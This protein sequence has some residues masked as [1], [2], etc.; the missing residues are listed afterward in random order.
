MNVDCFPYANHWNL[1][2][3]DLQYLGSRPSSTLALGRYQEVS[4][5]SKAFTVGDIELIWLQLMAPS[6]IASLG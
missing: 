6:G 1:F 5:T 4:R 3:N 2:A